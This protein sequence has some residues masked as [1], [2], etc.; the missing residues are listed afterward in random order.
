LRV[1]DLETGACLR[2]LEGQTGVA[3]GV[4]VTPDGHRAVVASWN[5]RLRVWDLQTGACLRV[6]EGHTN[7]VWGIIMTP[8]GRR[9]ASASYDNTVRVWD[10][11]IAACLAVLRLPAPS[12]SVGL[13][14]QLGQVIVGTDN[15]EVLQFD[16]LGASLAPSSRPLKAPSASYN[17]E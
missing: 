14:P 9:L 3:D 17:G 8:D 1:W 13:S 10:L 11:E 7:R 16:L 6:L 12:G 15:G 5:G 4:S 2:V